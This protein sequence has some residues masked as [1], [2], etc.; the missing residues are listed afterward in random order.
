MRTLEEVKEYFKGVEIAKCVASKKEFNFADADERGIHYS[1]N[2]YWIVD[3]NRPISH[4]VYSPNSD[5]FSE[6]IS[7]PVFCGSEVQFYSEILGEWLDLS[8]DRKYRIKPDYSKEIA[9]LERQIQE[10]KNR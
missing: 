6:I 7:K 3:G 5:E 10:L 8:D 9:E 2:A 4:M 1:H